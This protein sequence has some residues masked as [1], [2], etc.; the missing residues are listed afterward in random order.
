MWQALSH[1]C[2]TTSA[3]SV[4]LSLILPDDIVLSDLIAGVLRY[5][6]WSDEVSSGDPSTLP[7]LEEVVAFRVRHLLDHN[8]ERLTQLFYRFDV[9]ES[10]IDA[11]FADCPTDQLP[12]GLADIL[13]Q[14][15]I[16]RIRSRRRFESESSI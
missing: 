1:R 12:E 15:E 2:H 6:Q 16:A 3:Y 5:F 10:A 11:L 13:I 7:Q 14:R 4:V 9:S 8:L